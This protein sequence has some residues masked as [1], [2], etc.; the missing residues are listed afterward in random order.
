MSSRGFV[1]PVRH[2]PAFGPRIAY[3][4]RS[5]ADRHRDLVNNVGASLISPIMRVFAL[6]CNVVWHPLS[7]DRR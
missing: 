7:P 1:S 6:T 2:E 3:G 4:R 5:P